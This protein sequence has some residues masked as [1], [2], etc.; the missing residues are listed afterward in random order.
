MCAVNLTGTQTTWAN[1][2]SFR[3]SV[4]NDFDSHEVRLPSSVGTSVRMGNLVSKLHFL[5]AVC[6]FCHVSAPPSFGGRWT[7]LKCNGYILPFWP[8][9][10]K[11]FFRYFYLFYYVCKSIRRGIWQAAEI[12]ITLIVGKSQVCPD[13]RP[14]NGNSVDFY[15]GSVIIIM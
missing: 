6:A 7:R 12:Y 4:L 1:I 5:T 2:N 10:C 11:H 13:K 3:S 9:E 8:R 15:R 14:H